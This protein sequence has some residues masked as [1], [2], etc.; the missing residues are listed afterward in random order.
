MRSYRELF[1]SQEFTPLFLTVTAQVAAQTVG[2]LAL[3]TQVYAA[4][5]S[6]LLSAL[7]MFGP[8]LAH[9]LGATTLLSAADR[10]PPRAALTGLA[11]LYGMA[12][13]ALALPG[14]PLWGVFAI[15]LGQGLAAALNG[16]VRYGLLTEILPEDGYLLG[17]SMLNMA[18][19]GMQ[20][21]GFAVGGV[22][23]AVLS[24]RG[25]LLAGACLYLVA[26]AVA[27]FG[28]TRR[29][30]R[31]CGRPSVRETWRVNAELW[32]SVP[33]RYVYLAMWV[34]NGLIVGAESLI[35]PYDP[36]HAG[37]LLA[38]SAV[39]M[40][41]GDLIAGRFLPAHW[42]RAL[43]LPGRLLLAAPFLIFIARPPLPVALAAATVATLGYASTLMLQERLIALT[44]AGIRG[45]ALG[46]QTSGMLTM[47]G[48]CA[49][50]AGAIA[51]WT[52][53]ATAMTVMAALSIA[54]TP[55]LSGPGS[56]LPRSLPWPP[57]GR[58]SGRPARS[59]G[60]SRRA[61][62]PAGSR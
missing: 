28:L 61:R 60:S 30:P 57:R 44:P 49:A 7:S 6:P 35:V 22:L 37:L 12:T 47:Q 42:R 14:L 59:G 24:P 43:E 52:S 34:P 10:L 21:A 41:A 4:T 50:L 55:A 27:R 45:Q 53:P 54:V 56:P 2:G 32:S 26:A 5:G 46:L 9:V 39:G 18:N 16:G 13:A 48:V 19:G 29:P 36:A 20:I 17:R 62:R 31:A 40:L 11:L 1:R 51:Q 8:S 25:V 3:A 33:R 38:G 23:L 15:I 58:G